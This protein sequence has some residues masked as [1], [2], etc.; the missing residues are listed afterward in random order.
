MENK[1]QGIASAQQDNG[2]TGRI[3]T[4]K[5]SKRKLFYSWNILK[6][7]VGFPSPEN[8]WEKIRSVK[9]HFCVECF[10]VPEK[11]GMSS[12]HTLCPNV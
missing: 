9:M 10:V 3:S 11:R 1:D 7:N 12:P 8:T 6:M 4:E 2:K 5:H